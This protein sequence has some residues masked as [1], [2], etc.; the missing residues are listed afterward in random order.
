MGVKLHYPTDVKLKNSPLVEAWLEIRW[1]LSLDPKTGIPTDSSYPFALGIFFKSVKDVFKHR[2]ELPSSQAPILIPYSVQ[3]RFRTEKDGWPLLQ[4]GPGIASLNFGKEYTWHSFKSR[5]SYFREQL[6]NAYQGTELKT[7]AV[8]LR[9]RNAYPY[10][11]SSKNLLDFFKRLNIQI[12]FPQNIPG[13]ASTAEFPLQQNLT[14]Q[15]DLVQPKGTGKINI[16]SAISSEKSPDDKN[17]VWDL[18]IGSVNE[19]APD[20]NDEIAFSQWLAD[21]HTIL[22]EWFF[23]LIE[24]SLFQEFSREG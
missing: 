13:A 14:F 16:A 8:F 10:D 5:A 12:E 22:H 21:A 4:L 2:E 9:Y 20:I 6:L 23:S 1:N 19:D 11:Y 15:Y 3:H 7:V 18:E 24:G 17:I